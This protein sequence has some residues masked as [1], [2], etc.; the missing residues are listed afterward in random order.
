MLIG[1]KE[2]GKPNKVNYLQEGL[3]LP[4]R[5]GNIS[6]S[7]NFESHPSGSITIQDVPESEI[8]AYR[9]AYNVINKL[10]IFFLNLVKL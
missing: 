9:L 5:K 6:V 4:I 2:T 10:L 7:L 1:I 3:P 8:N